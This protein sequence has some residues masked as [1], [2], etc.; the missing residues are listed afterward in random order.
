M[1]M[2]KSKFLLILIIVT[3][4][5]NQFAVSQENVKIK[6]GEFIHKYEGYK[7]AWNAVKKGNGFFDE[8][9]AQYRSAREMYLKAYNYNS[10]NAELNYKIGVCFLYADDKLQ[11]IKYL[12]KAFDLKHEVAD[13][14]HFQMARA[15]HMSQDFDNAISI[16]N[17]K[18]RKAT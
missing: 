12:K 18:F 6:K 4:L 3:V 1:L 17:K 2:N 11:A 7:D 13:D 9:K 14:I 15:F 8:G 16:S 10:Q 5:Y